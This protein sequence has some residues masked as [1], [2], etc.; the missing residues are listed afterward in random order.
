MIKIGSFLFSPFRKFV[1]Q[2]SIFR[3][4]KRTDKDGVKVSTRE[5]SKIFLWKTPESVSVLGGAQRK[6][7]KS[8]GRFPRHLSSAR[9][10][11]VRLG[12]HL[13]AHPPD[14]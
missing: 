14:T 5:K 8:E 2:I 12:R 9:N 3:R 10:A 13:A 7:R 1:Q 11:I 4:S 6:S